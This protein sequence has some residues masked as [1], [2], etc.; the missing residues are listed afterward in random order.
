[1]VTSLKHLEISMRLPN[2]ED[3]PFDHTYWVANWDEIHNILGYNKNDVEATYQFFLIT[4]GETDLPLYKGKNRLQL[5]KDIKSKFGL[6]CFN[7]NDVKI[8]DELNKLNY[9]KNNPGVQL[10]RGGTVRPFINLGD[11]I[12]P[13]IKFESDQLNEFLKKLKTITLTDEAMKFEEEIVYKGVRLSFGL[14]GIHSVDNPRI[15]IPKPHEKLEDRDCT[16][17]HPTV[18]LKYGFYP[19]HLGKSWLSGYQWTFDQR[20]KNKKLSKDKSLSETERKKHDSIQEAF[21]LSLNGG[22]FGKTGELSS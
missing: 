16:S 6:P 10:I 7:Y 11:C 1:M 15:I 22:G 2:V 14:G 21:K 3:M 5:R 8:G 12:L 20:V 9:L 17:M 18:I 4:I 13:N 19:E